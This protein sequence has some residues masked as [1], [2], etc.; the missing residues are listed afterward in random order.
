MAKLK[1]ALIIGGA[2]TS[3]SKLC[4]KFI[5][6]DY[7][8]F[9]V[10]DLS[11]EHAIHPSKW[12]VPYN[13]SDSNQFIFIEEE[14]SKFFQMEQDCQT[15]F[16]VIVMFVQDKKDVFL[17]WLKSLSYTPL[18]IIYFKHLTPLED[19]VEIVNHQPTHETES[20]LI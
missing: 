5:V 2:N 1:T 19:I 9:C 18:H 14:C 10:D 12:A 7:Y 16:D 3:G 17:Q 6:Q 15:Q 11:G 4:T 8:T 13:C 20:P